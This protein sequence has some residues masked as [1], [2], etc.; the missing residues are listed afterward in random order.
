[1]LTIARG[2]RIVRQ[3]LRS[4]ARSRDV[5]AELDAELAFHL[6]AFVAE[7]MADGVPEADAR[8]AARRAFG[9]VTRVGEDCRDARRVNWI[10]DAVQDA[11]YGVRQLRANPGVATA[12]VASLALG[13]GVLGGALRGLDA[14]HAGVLGVAD[15]DRYVA[16]QTVSPTGERRGASAIDVVAWR[17][18]SDA[19]DLLAA[20]LSSTHTIGADGASPAMRARTLS[21][22]SSYFDTI[23][24]RPLLGRG[25]TRE[26]T[27]LV[28]PA[29]AIVISEDLWRTRY[30]ADPAILTRYVRVGG[31][32]RAI[33]GVMP[34]SIRFRDVEVDIWLPLRLLP[35]VP[36]GGGRALGVCG[37]LKPGVTIAAA[38]AQLDGIAAGIGEQFG[39]RFAG[40][41]TA[42]EPLDETRLG[43]SRQ[44]LGILTAIGALVLV[45]ACANVAGLMLARAA[46]RQHE[47]QLR[48]DLGASRGRLARQWIAEGVVL[49]VFG[50]IAS[51]V[52]MAV[53]LRGLGAVTGPPG[54]PPLA[55]LAL[56]A[57]AMGIGAIVAVAAGLALGAAPAW[58]ASSR[59]R[60]STPWPLTRTILT[61]TQVAV[62]LVVVVAS[63]LLLTSILKLTQRDLG[64]EPDGLLTF[65]AAVPS[66]RRDIALIDG[67]QYFEVTSQP[68]RT[69]TRI[70]DAVR[71]VP[72][73]TSAG[74][75]S[76][77]AIDAFV[78]PRF[79]VTADGRALPAVACAFITP[80]YFATMGAL[81]H[82]GRDID[83]RDDSG[84]PWVAVVNASAAA[85][86][87]PGDTAIGKTIRVNTVPD[88]R[89]RVVVGVVGDIPLRHA[90][91]AE[92]IVYESYLQQPA[93]FVAPWINLFGTMSFVVR[94]TGPA[95]AVR[96][97]LGR[98][99]ATVDPELPIAGVRRVNEGLAAGRSTLSGLVTLSTTLA[100]T[101]VLLAVVGIHGVVA[102]GVRRQTREIAVRMT[103]GAGPA[104]VVA[105]IGRR[106]AVILAAG[107]AAG[108]AAALPTM[109][110]IGSYLWGVTTTDPGTYLV[111]FAI[112]AGI[113]VVAC[114]AP[115]RRAVRIDPTAALKVD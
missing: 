43:W 27:R 81:I 31:T 17:D 79:D 100:M 47:I 42:F 50:G 12:A 13:I 71:R 87:W 44:P 38:Q 72:G 48:L 113:A 22:T 68:A 26:E 63:G 65:E 52:V 3:R 61:A 67:R 86:L 55:P 19:F 64:F 82:D 83:E 32:P 70:A 110:L 78:V 54:A 28:D 76:F 107:L 37:R 33:V 102:Y 89:P 9:N 88:D 62:T 56:D 103:L 39:E 96:D 49:G 95:D 51:L 91:S 11:I 80:G 57:R 30:G 108:A 6:N 111:A 20:T 106:V 98:V 5:D 84:A 7:Q 1:M 4:V 104:Q 53:A 18:R 114:V 66:T 23:A 8:L 112:I 14:A 15:A 29:P 41:T 109:H 16:I 36:L 40:W 101:S 2:L 24:A 92:P 85:K 59:R 99:A 58:L 93:R 60:R 97:S 35:T 94:H 45:V 105:L 77:R 21:V 90:Q 74:G 73:V 34:A 10:A 69:I 75:S 46:A 25:F 115:V